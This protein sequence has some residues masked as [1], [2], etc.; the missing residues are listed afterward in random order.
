ME[1]RSR[2]TRV[3]ACGAVKSNWSRV[4]RNEEEASPVE[5]ASHSTG[6]RG[7]KARS[8]GP[9]AFGAPGD[10]SNILENDRIS[11]VWHC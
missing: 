8:G 1:R 4:A 11:V 10:Y 2:E 9:G 7:E 5:Y 6:E 3:S